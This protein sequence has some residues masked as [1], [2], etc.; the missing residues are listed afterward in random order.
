MDFE[1]PVAG[2]GPVKSSRYQTLDQEKRGRAWPCLPGPRERPLALGDYPSHRAANVSP[3]PAAPPLASTASGKNGIQIIIFPMQLHVLW[4]V[5][6]HS[7]GS[8]DPY[9]GKWV[10]WLGPRP[11]RLPG[12]GWISCGQT[13]LRRHP[14]MRIK[15]RD[16][17]LWLWNGRANSGRS[18]VVLCYERLYEWTGGAPEVA[19]TRGDLCASMPQSTLRDTNRFQLNYAS[20]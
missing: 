7:V 12:L 19:A 18:Y 20:P 3:P 6:G 13:T 5:C 16:A 15:S 4:P 10:G 17:L 1:N 2:D 9:C 11:G 14:Q 8:M